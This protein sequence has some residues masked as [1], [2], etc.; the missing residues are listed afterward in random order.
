MED[1]I[2]RNGLAGGGFLA[3]SC[4]SEENVVCGCGKK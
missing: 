2:V 3:T 1:E 4:F